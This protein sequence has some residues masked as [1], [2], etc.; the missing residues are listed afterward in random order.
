[1]GLKFDEIWDDWALVKHP[2]NPNK[3]KIAF[4][5][6]YFLFL[7]IFNYN[8]A[9]LNSLHKYSDKNYEFQ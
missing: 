5:F 2:N 8:F 1:V 4:I 3:S 9:L 7:L 6:F